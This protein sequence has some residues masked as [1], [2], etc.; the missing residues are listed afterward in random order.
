MSTHQLKDGRWFVRYPKGTLPD[1]PNRTR[2]YF[3]RGPAAEAA[4]KVRSAEVK[5]TYYKKH[6]P[7]RVSPQFSKLASD[8]QTSRDLPTVSA[9]NLYWKMKSVILPEI[10][11]IEAINL[12]RERLDQYVVKRREKVKNTTIHRELSDIQAV[13]NWSVE[14]KLLALNPVAGY[15][16][17]KRDDA[18]IRPPSLDEVRLILKHSSEHLKRSVLISYFCGIRPGV[19]ELFRMQWDDIDWNAETILVYSANK[20]GPPLREI[21]LHN[22]FL[23]C[24]NCWYESDLSLDRIPEFIIRWR[25]QPISKMKTAWRRAKERAGITRRIRPYDVR[26][27]LATELLRH[28]ADLKSVSEILGHSRPDTTARIYQHVDS[29]MRRNAIGKLP[30]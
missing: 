18:R 17:P 5:E 10:G 27:A 25:G 22:V 29:E 21:H 1:Q 24:L 2:E 6:S 9:K 12:T 20:G 8:Y 11:K 14:N 19:E 23:D 16:K 4:A 26:H 13:L 15:K 30:W 28:G 3:G 7:K